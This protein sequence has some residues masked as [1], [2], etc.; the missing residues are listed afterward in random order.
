MQILKE[1]DDLKEEWRGIEFF[2]KKYEVSNCGNVR[3]LWFGKIKPIKLQNN[4]HGYLCFT[5]RNGKDKPKT[6][7]VHVAVAEAFLGERPKGLVINHKDG[8]KHNNNVQNLEYVTYSEN[9][10]HALRTGLR[11]TADMNKLVVKRGEDN[12]RAKVTEEQVKQFL[13]YHYETGYGYRRVA[14]HFGV[15]HSIVK[16]IL[17]GKNWK[18]VDRES[19][20]KEVEENA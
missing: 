17:S 15:S 10:L 18:H 9:N 14:K 11:K 3:S 13:K 16:D 20:K 5:A 7:R 1:V 12:Y 8:N 19:I 6:I 2:N 4:R